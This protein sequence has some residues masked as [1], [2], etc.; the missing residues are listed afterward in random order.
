MATAALR[1]TPGLLAGSRAPAI[2]ERNFIVY[3]HSWVLF[4]SGLLEPLFYLLALGVGVGKLVGDITGPD[5]Q[6]LSYAAFVAPAMLATS[7]MNGAVFDSTFNVFFKLKYAKLYDGVLATPVTPMDIAVGEI[8]WA[9][10]R[11]ASYS[12]AF[13]AFMVLVGLVESWW[14]VLVVPAALLVGF[15]FAAAGM[16][17]TTYMRSWQDFEW[18]TLATLPM[19]LLL[20]TFY[21]L[22]TYPPAL[23]TVVRWTPLYQGVDLVRSL[24]TGVLHPGLVANV[25]YLLVMGLLGLLVARRRLAALLLR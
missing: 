14:A 15:A 23:R 5:G 3:R 2:V 13:L 7:A 4:I 9:L 19:F 22:T 17:A 12:T 18:V 8:A 1:L 20:G 6:T 10:A 25:A 11:G 24:T 21:P 16:A